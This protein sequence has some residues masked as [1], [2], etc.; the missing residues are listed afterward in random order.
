MYVVATAGHVDHGKSTLVK[1]LTGQE[2]DRWE[3]EKRRGLTID[4]GF[5]WTTLPSGADVAFVDVPGHEKFLGNMLAGV[6]PAPAVL[7]IVAADEGWQA[8]SDDHRDAVNAFGITGVVIAM[9]RADRADKSR[10]EQTRVEIRR[11]VAGTTLEHAPIVEVAATT[12]EGI[13]ALCFALDAMLAASPPPDP[14]AR[15]RLWIDRRFS[16]KGAGTVVTGTLTG[17]T[18]EVGQTLELSGRQ[19]QVRG[20]QSKDVPVQSMTPAARLAVNLRG[21]SA[22]QVSRGDVLLTPEAWVVTD[23]VDIRGMGFDSPPREV[24]THLGTA[25][26]DTAFRR[27][28]DTHAR[29]TLSRALPLQ[30]GD[31]LVLRK[32]GERSVYAGVQVLDVDPPE[33]G[34][35]GAGTRRARELEQMS[36]AGDAAHEVIRRGALRRGELVRMGVDTPVDPPRGIVAF[37]EYWVH[38]ATLM[39]WRDD[40]RLA[41]DQHVAAEP[42]SP[43]LSRGAALSTLKLPD[44]ALFG[45]VVA[46]AKLEQGDGVLRRPGST[47][48]LGAAAAGVA[49]LERRLSGCAFAAPESGELSELGLGSRE[50]AAAERAGRIL[51]LGDGVVLLP[52]AP[53]EAVARLRQLEQPFTTSAARKALGTTRRVAIPLLEHLDAVGRTRRIDGSLREIR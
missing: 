33:L 7:F 6:G 42:L 12:G 15:L 22:D 50:L 43:G 52:S 27:L 36:P 1:T 39:R 51:R 28:S 49:E 46:A 53:V 34:R 48:D 18:V 2:P 21:L 35:R 47:V 13:D 38:A 20:L 25:A 8:Q 11:E 37:G 23:T 19:V 9:T 14:H 44:D 40:L 10:R 3:E 45:L 17:G 31:R 5:V 26:V 16:V 4:L 24:V 32:P 30:V 29:L 41:L